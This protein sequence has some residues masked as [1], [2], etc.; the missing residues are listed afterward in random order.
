MKQCGFM[1][2]TPLQFFNCDGMLRHQFQN[3]S[4]LPM[5]KESINQKFTWINHKKVELIKTLFQKLTMALII[6]PLTKKKRRSDNC[7]IANSSDKNAKKLNF[8][9]QTKN[10]LHA[11]EWHQLQ[12]TVVSWKCIFRT[13]NVLSKE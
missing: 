1:R 10:L 7:A 13:Q 12:A 2:H 8:K 4:T 11:L 5:S 9:R 6:G 3:E